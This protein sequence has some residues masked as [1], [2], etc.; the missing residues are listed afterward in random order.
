VVAAPVP[1]ALRPVPLTP[2]QQWPVSL[3][4]LEEEAVLAGTSQPLGAQLG[5][6]PLSS[7][8]HRLLGRS[9]S[10]LSF[11][12]CPWA[13]PVASTVEEEAHWPL[14]G[15]GA[16]V[17]PDLALAQA[18]PGPRLALG[19]MAFSSI[20]GTGLQ[21]AMGGHGARVGA[22]QPL[23]FI[24]A[25]GEGEGS[26]AAQGPVRGLQMVVLEEAAAGWTSAAL[27]LPS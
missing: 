7:P 9:T 26:M 27:W 2:L 25:Q 11:V 17:E 19:A 8:M 21:G 13:G 24:Q 16:P 5:Q 6:G 22:L 1:W 18:L 4:L 12:A 10:L 20:M 23:G 3:Q 15:R 14:L